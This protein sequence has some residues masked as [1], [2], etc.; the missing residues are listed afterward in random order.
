MLPSTR[1]K[2]V[3][4]HP[5]LQFQGVDANRKKNVERELISLLETSWKLFHVPPLQMSPNALF[6]SKAVI[7]LYALRKI[8]QMDS[9]GFLFAELV[10]NV[11]G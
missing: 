2:L 11:S 3:S 1:G 7:V 5:L 10:D 6:H 9:F 4:A 8:I